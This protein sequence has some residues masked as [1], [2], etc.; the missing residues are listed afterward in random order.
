MNKIFKWTL[1]ILLIQFASLFAVTDTIVLQQGLNGYDG[2]SDTYIGQ[3][4]PANSNNQGNEDHLNVGR[5]WS[6]QSKIRA[7]SKFDLSDFNFIQG[8]TSSKASYFLYETSGQ[9][10]SDNI[11]LWYLPWSFNE[12]TIVGNDKD[13]WLSTTSTAISIINSPAGDDDSWL[14]FDIPV[15][16]INSFI[17]GTKTNNGFTLHGETNSIIRERSFCSKEYSQQDLRPKLTIIYDM[18]LYAKVIKPGASESLRPDS[19]YKIIWYSNSSSPFTIELLKNNV[20]VDTIAESLVSSPYDWTIPKHKY[21]DGADYSIRISD[22]SIKSTNNPLFEI[23]DFVPILTVTGGMGGGSHT[24]SSIV[25]ISGTNPDPVNK[26][27]VVWR[28]DVSS[29]S[30]TLSESTTLTM[31]DKDISVVAIYDFSALTISGKLEAEDPQYKGGYWSI[32]SDAQYGGA[33]VAGNGTNSDSTDFWIS[34]RCNVEKTGTY[35]FDIRVAHE[36]NLNI[37]KVENVETGSVL[38]RYELQGT[39]TGWF[40]LEMHKETIELQQGEQTLRF[41][42]FG[43]GWF[44]LDYLELTFLNDD[45][46][47]EGS[48]KNN[49]KSLELS[50]VAN[51]IVFHIPY[52]A[53][54]YEGI[55]LSLYNARGI[56][57]ETLAKGNMKTGDHSISLNNI[58]N[59]VASGFYLCVLKSS[60]MKKVLPI[61]IDW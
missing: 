51:S 34:Y 48:L 12:F 11:W 57:V 14:D 20:V 33:T 60:G 59:K 26:E 37:L 44:N 43:S 19:S 56:K 29:I 53:N 13:S 50:K 2:A 21:T 22:G 58:K 17:A 24:A 9:S 49:N 5:C 31:P 35:T 10:I 18:S 15:S 41:Y 55:S 8:I 52:N 16:D 61:F 27:F 42:V 46:K 6:G 3:G 4:L 38:G 1:L 45:V 25:A 28:G 39:K 54:K 32:S 47:I 23:I 7:I 40:D 36:D 30:D